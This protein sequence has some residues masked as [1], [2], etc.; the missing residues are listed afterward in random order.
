[1]GNTF[2]Q[3]FRSHTP[4]SI[5]AVESAGEPKLEAEH[6]RGRARWV[7]AFTFAEMFVPE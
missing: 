5:T 1:M 4:D 7:D 2:V 3:L 6:T